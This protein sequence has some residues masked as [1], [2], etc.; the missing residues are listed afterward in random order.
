MAESKEA[1]PVDQLRFVT[2]SLEGSSLSDTVAALIQTEPN[3]GPSGVPQ[4]GLNLVDFWKKYHHP[5]R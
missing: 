5:R 1:P 3:H 4:M 2:K